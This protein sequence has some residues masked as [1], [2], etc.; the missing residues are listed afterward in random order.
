M[1]VSSQ[2]ASTF[3]V[4]IVLIAFMFILLPLN[5]AEARSGTEKLGDH[6]QY[7]LPLYALGRSSLGNDHAGTRQLFYSFSSAA[8]T[9][10]G[11]KE[12]T[13][14]K[15]PDWEPGDRKRSFPSG[16]ATHAFSS[17]MFIHQRYGLHEAV[18]P[19]F[20]AAVVAYSRVDA[21]KHYVHDVLGSMAVSAI[22]TQLLVSKKVGDKHN[23]VIGKNRV[24]YVRK[25]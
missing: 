9:T 13:Q 2:K 23:V 21:K 25:F 22:Y 5:Q 11:L 1:N 7:A 12:L 24:Y 20:L 4:A 3:P 15:R 16:H 6:L 19:Y 8:L 14:Q 17:A 18:V 10:Q